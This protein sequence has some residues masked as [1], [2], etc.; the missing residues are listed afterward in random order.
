M[1]VNAK[2][3]FWLLLAERC[4]NSGVL[5]V[6]T[7]SLSVWVQLA[8]SLCLQFVWFC[9][10]ILVGTR[11]LG[12]EAFTRI[13]KQVQFRHLASPHKKNVFFGLGVRFKVKVKIRARN[14]VRGYV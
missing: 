3:L 9:F 4:A 7:P 1:R 8:C 12:P 5:S 2:C 6:P 11:S 10:P 13:V 14:R